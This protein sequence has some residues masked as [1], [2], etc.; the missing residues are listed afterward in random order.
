MNHTI[1]YNTKTIE[2]FAMPS[3]K[4]VVK[5]I[6]HKK[7][8]VKLIATIKGKG[9]YLADAAKGIVN[10]VTYNNDKTSLGAAARTVGE[11]AGAYI[12]PALSKVLGNAASWFTSLFGGGR[13]SVKRNSLL[14]A[15]YSQV[16]GRGSYKT[17]LAYSPSSDS[18]FLT[19]SPP[20]FSN[21]GKGF[22][23]DII[24]SHREY[25]CDV[26]SSTGFVST[27]YPIN[28]GNPVLFP[29]LSK[30]AALYEE[31]EFLGLIFE[32]KTMSAAAVG[33][34]SSA[35]GNVIMA[36]DY[37]CMD[38]NFTNKRQMESAEFACSTVP[39]GTF[40][41]PIECELSLIHI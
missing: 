10:A 6:R 28:P 7:K 13:Y 16:S 37:D 17:N 14:R 39:Y 33:T 29:W 3:K 38:S 23:S 24:L 4:H 34:V 20:M 18:G 25:V 32:Y 1:K 27:A 9:G 19:N 31:F 2:Y 22:G 41:H 5:K 8:K 35:M 15:A 11:A 36:T 26:N 40:V 30:V 12:H 21:G